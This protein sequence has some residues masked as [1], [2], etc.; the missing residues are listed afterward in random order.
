MRVLSRVALVVIV[1][2]LAV[3]LFADHFQGDCP[4]SLVANNPASS[5][6]N[7][8]PHGAF[9]SGS[10]V[11]VLR[12][13]TLTTYTLTDLGDM[14]IA[15]E[16]FIGSLGARETNGGVTFNSG[17]LYV[18]SEAGLE[19]FDLRN[20]R[21]GGAAP[22]LVSRTPGLHYRRLAVSGNTLAA[23]YP[24]TDMP[25]YPTGTTFCFNTID[26]FDVSNK[27]VP[28]RTGSISSLNSR[29]FLGWNDIAFNQGFLYAAGEGGSVGF[30]ISN[31]A[32]PVSL[33]QIMVP[34]K[35]II[36][37]NTT[38]LAIGNDQTINIYNVALSGAVGLFQI[39]VLPFETITR[40][41]PIAFHRQGFIDEQNGRMV[42][43]VD[44]IDPETLKPARTVAI[45]VFDF[46]VPLWE[47]SYERIY[48]NVSYTTPDEVKFNPIAAGPFVYVVGSISGLQTYGACGNMAGEI[49]W[50]GTQ[51][52]SCLGTEIRGWVTGD[53]K[54]ANVEL[55]LDSGSLGSTPV[56][57]VPRSDI[58]SR[59]PVLTWHINFDSAALSST[60]DVPVLRTLRAVG[61]DVLGNRRQFASQRILLFKG[62]NC[63][64][65]RRSA[66]R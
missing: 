10:Q 41:N 59:T 25:C 16:D 64:N 46:T 55:F 14:Q 33:G 1:V 61:T 35:F 4:L 53:Q 29:S 20:V 13:Q 45:D 12:G 65:R 38:L 2:F 9:R 11:F 57:G 17:F 60:S 51:A 47:G 30:N 42:T 54:I 26:L 32:A 27:S 44:E 66:G 36:S 3:P 63:T 56:G 34:G 50:D 62:T 37:N 8:S 7:L 19:I 24:S 5:D 22:A 21:P 39:Y 23:L 48:E 6:F 43:M 58:S 15:R 18:S 52:L 31:P 28:I 49:E 40:A